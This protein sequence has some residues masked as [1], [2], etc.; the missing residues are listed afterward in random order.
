MTT[1]DQF[2]LHQDNFIASLGQDNTTNTSW[3]KFFIENR[4]EPLIG[5]AFYD[6]LI[7]EKFLYR[8]REIYAKL[9][10]IFPKEKPALLHGDLWSGNVLR[11]NSGNPAL[12]DPAVYYGNREM[13]LA[14]SRLFG[15]FD[16]GFYQAYEAV[17]PLEPDF[18]IRTD[19]YNLYP[20]L[21][22]LHLFGKSY[23]SGIE[24]TINRLLD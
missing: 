9:E 14:F 20:L 15:G 23:L 8:F 1:A 5:K 7:S 6:S 22:H 10:S 3:T 17:F 18:E 24:K 13:D 21:V 16:E 4:L 19:I 12:I 11:D 2:G